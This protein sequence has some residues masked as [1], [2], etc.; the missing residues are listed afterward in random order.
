MTLPA[1]G[2]LVL[3][4]HKTAF[5]L[6]TWNYLDVFRPLLRLSVIQ[7]NEDTVHANKYTKQYFWMIQ[8]DYC[9]ESFLLKQI[10][11]GLMSQMGAFTSLARTC[12]YSISSSY[13]VSMWSLVNAIG[14]KRIFF[15]PLSQ[16]P[17]IVSS[18]WGPSQ[19]IG[20]TY[21][22]G[23]WTHT[24]THCSHHVYDPS[25]P[26]ALGTHEPPCRSESHA[27]HLL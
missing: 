17:L 12:E 27:L 20:P 16:S 1:V 2:H 13:S 22:K 24:G 26:T 14:T 6:L 3:E 18:V 5:P 23:E 25:Q 7:N 9:R 15:L 19:G 4:R 10:T 8:L 11:M 21:E